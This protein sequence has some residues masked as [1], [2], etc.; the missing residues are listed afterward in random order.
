M[1]SMNGIININKKK[2][3]TNINNINSSINSKIW[4]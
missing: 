3:I 2:T 4:I 1:N